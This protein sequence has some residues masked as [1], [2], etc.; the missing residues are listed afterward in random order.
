MIRD[1]A[2]FVTVSYM[3]K[4]VGVVGGSARR[5]RRHDAPGQE[6]DDECGDAG[7]GGAHDDEGVRRYEND[8]DRVIQFVAALLER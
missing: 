3:T 1:D 8:G 6:G 4:R 5:L 7:C 2:G